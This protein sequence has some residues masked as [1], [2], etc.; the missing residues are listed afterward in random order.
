MKAPTTCARIGCLNPP[1]VQRD[2][3]RRPSIYCSN[4]CKQKAWRDRWRS[5][6]SKKA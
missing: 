1:R 3:T 5:Y 4:A 6:P 2:K